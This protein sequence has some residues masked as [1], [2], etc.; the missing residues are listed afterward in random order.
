MRYERYGLQYNQHALLF[1][2][3]KYVDSRFA[4]LPATVRDVHEVARVLCDPQYCGYPREN[5]HVFTNCEATIENAR[6][7]LRNLSTIVNSQSVVFLFFSGHGGR[8]LENDAPET[9][10]CFRDSNL[11]TLQMSGMSGDEFSTLIARVQCSK[12]VVILDACHS[13][14]S[15]S[16]K[17]QMPRKPWKSGLANNYLAS[18]GEGAGRV[19]IASSKAEQNSYVRSTGD[20]SLF[21]WYL[22]EGLRG[23]ASIRGDGLV[24][25]FDL[26]TYVSEKVRAEC[27]QQ[28]PILHA[29]DVDDNF[30]M[31]FRP[32]EVPDAFLSIHE[33][34]EVIL[35]D[36]LEGARLLS[37]YMLSKELYQGID[38]VELK[39]AVLERIRKNERL[40]GLTKD[41]EVERNRAIHALL[42]TCMDL[43]I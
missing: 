16:L 24:R 10:L 14:G 22:I 39:R 42:R 1:G 37:E 31:A 23:G 41:E 21:S 6:T 34:R 25:I 38:A 5:V 36:S 33:I 4:D 11:D 3:G 28:E 8:L 40:F 29:K 27:N 9:F 13:G 20:F 35:R 7:A 32:V 17:S 15:A 19:V 26:F 2:V 43:E 18:L 12:L 30:A